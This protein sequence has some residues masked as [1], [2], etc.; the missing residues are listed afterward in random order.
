LMGPAALCL[1]GSALANPK[2]GRFVRNS[3]AAII[4]A[5]AVALYTYQR[6]FDVK[7]FEISDERRASAKALRKFVRNLGDKTLSP[8]YPYLATQG[9]SKLEQSDPMPWFDAMWSGVRNVS[10]ADYFERVAPEYVILS[11]FEYGVV[12]GPI[13]DKLILDQVCED[14]TMSSVLMDGVS[15]PNQAFVRIR[16]RKHAHCLFDF[17]RNLDGWNLSGD[18]FRGIQRRNWGG[19]LIGAEGSGLLNSQWGGDAPRGIAVSPEFRLD[20][21]KLSLR[22][23]GGKAPGLRVELV[24]DDHVVYSE[25]G[26]RTDSLKEHIWDVQHLA[27]KLARLRVVDD[28][29]ESWGHIMLDSVCLED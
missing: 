3:P 18:A 12:M 1:A 4:V 11:G 6:S 8:G 21:R 28:V 14:C 19:E 13:A 16:K 9:G 7:G 27:G 17:E 24:V 10:Y 23:G 15:L 29:G 22:V 20:Q 26:L 5:Y 25:T 2:N